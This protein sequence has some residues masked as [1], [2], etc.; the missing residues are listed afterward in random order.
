[1]VATSINFLDQQAAQGD[2][3]IWLQRANLNSSDA[4]DCIDLMVLNARIH[5]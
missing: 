5:M 4:L 3:A 2:Y 1:M